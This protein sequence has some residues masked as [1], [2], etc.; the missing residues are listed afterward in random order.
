M[1]KTKCILLPKN[2][3]D[4]KR[5]SIM[6]RHTLNDGITP[7]E[8]I[9]KNLYDEWR[10]KFAPPLK[11]VGDYYRGLSW[12]EFEK[13]YLDYLGTINQK[14]KELVETASSKD[15]TLL[16][17]EES[18]ERYHRRLLAKECKRIKP[19]LEILIN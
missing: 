10:R 9:D 2:Y 5:I 7:D 14:I 16:C 6:S 17:V 1:L 4:G 19:K 15:I 8:R 3:S 13:R 12:E 11:L 18:P